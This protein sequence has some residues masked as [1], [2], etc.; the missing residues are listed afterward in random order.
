M[1][2]TQSAR[3]CPNPQ[4]THYGQHG[5]GAHLVQ[6]GVDR[7][8]LR[9]LCSKCQSVY[10]A[11]QGTAYFWARAEEANYTIAMRALPEGN[12]LRSTGRTVETDKDIV[13]DWLD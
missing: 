1:Y 12:S 6:R 9:L 7:V 10:S 13:C 5:F 11:R 4:C 8:I 3:Y 2:D